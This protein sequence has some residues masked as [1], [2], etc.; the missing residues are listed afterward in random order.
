M[1]RCFQLIGTSQEKALR[2]EN[3]SL[4]RYQTFHNFWRGFPIKESGPLKGFT[5]YY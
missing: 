1:N 3:Q 4:V 5:K 2:S